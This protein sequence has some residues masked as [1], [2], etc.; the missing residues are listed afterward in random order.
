MIVEE[1]R[2]DWVRWGQVAAIALTAAVY[3]SKSISRR[4]MV[5]GANQELIIKT[6]VG[7]HHLQL[8]QW[9][10]R[11]ISQAITVQRAIIGLSA[12]LP[13]PEEQPMPFAPIDKPR[14]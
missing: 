11:S 7:G 2:F 5:G 10:I 4:L 1:E 8:D 12:A 14:T 3:V 9:L 6:A 13:P